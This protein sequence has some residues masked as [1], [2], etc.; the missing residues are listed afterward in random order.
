[1]SRCADLHRVGHLRGLEL[2]RHAARDVGVEADRDRPCAGA[3]AMRGA[4]ASPRSRAGSCRR[5][6]SPGRTCG[7]A[8]PRHSPAPSIASATAQR[9]QRRRGGCA[10]SSASAGHRAQPD[11]DDGD[12]EEQHHEPGEHQRR[13]RCCGS[14]AG[15]ASK[16]RLLPRGSCG[17]AIPAQT[18]RDP[19]PAPRTARTVE[20]RVP[21]Q[22]LFGLHRVAFGRT[23]RSADRAARQRH[24]HARDSASAATP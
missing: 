5:S 7:R 15:A 17:H 12:G 21:E 14:L 6:R 20:D 23:V 1:M 16:L 13:A 2:P 9:D 24:E 10:C 18:A 4:A 11:L 3:A 22:P 8:A 19:Q